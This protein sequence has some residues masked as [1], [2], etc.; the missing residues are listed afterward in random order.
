MCNR[1]MTIRTLWMCSDIKYKTEQTVGDSGRLYNS[2]RT[3]TP[4]NE[5][6]CYQK[7][8]C[9]KDSGLIFRGGGVGAHQN[10]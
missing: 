7:D 3:K 10:L 8:F 4:G 5:G 9:L 1:N 2:F 6:A